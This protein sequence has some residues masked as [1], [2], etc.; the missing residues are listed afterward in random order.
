MGKI[1]RFGQYSPPAMNSKG[2]AVASISFGNGPDTL[3]L[4][5]PATP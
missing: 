5:T 1:T 3:V 2:Q 4:L